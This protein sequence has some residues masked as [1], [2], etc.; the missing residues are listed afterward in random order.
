M[1]LK[2]EINPPFWAAGILLGAVSHAA[3]VWQD[4]FYSCFGLLIICLLQNN[5]T[6]PRLH[7]GFFGD[8]TPGR[9]PRR[10]AG[11]GGVL[12][13]RGNIN[14]RTACKQNDY[15]QNH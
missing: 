10:G 7:K 15:G 11:L 8:N 1:I 12:G 4:G 13:K 14:R 6:E 5:R 2:G 9:R 3:P